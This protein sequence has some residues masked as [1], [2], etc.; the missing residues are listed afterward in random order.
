MN[1]QNNWTCEIRQG[2]GG[3]GDEVEKTGVLHLKTY[4]QK[5]ELNLDDHGPPPK[6]IVKEEP[7][8]RCHCIFL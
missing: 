2:I 5:T 7:R 1:G 4:M 6:A 8:L 3:G